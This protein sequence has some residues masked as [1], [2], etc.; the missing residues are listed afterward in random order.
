VVRLEER[1]EL[2]EQGIDDL[3]KRVTDLEGGNDDDESVLN[4]RLSEVR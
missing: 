4:R 1:I 2:L 3:T